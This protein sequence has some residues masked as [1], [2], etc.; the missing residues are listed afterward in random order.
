MVVTNMYEV[1][2]GLVACERLVEIS[3]VS[4]IRAEVMQN[5]FRNAVLLLAEIDVILILGYDL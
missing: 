3:S 4:V 2:T 1:E 5:E